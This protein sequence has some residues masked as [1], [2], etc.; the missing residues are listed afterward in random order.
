[1]KTDPVCG[2]N[3][4]EAG[5]IHKSIFR[6][7]SYVFCSE[8]CQEAFEQHPLLYIEQEQTPPSERK[9]VVVG[10]GAVGSTFAYA[11]MRSGLAT[12]I[13]L[14]GRSPEKV[15]AHVMDLNH[16][17]MFVPPVDIY[18][19]TYADCKNA[20][21]V[22]VTSGVAQKPGESRIDLTKRNA[23][24]FRKI[25]PL[26]AREDPNSILVVTNPVDVLTYAAI[27]ISG[28]PMNR[29][30]GSGT[31]LDTARF[32]YLL[33][34][35]CGVDSRNVH[36]YILGEHG[37]SEVPA[38]SKVDIGGVTLKNYCPSCGK[39]CPREEMEGIFSQ[40]RNAAYEIIQGKG[41]TNFAIGL[42]MVRITEAIL[43]NE[44]SIL[45]VST[46]VDGLYNIRDVCLS[47]PA[48][49]NRNGVAKQINLDLEEDEVEMLR[50]SA[51]LLKKSIKEIGL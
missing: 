32:R 25:I 16:G 4:D 28:M 2:M 34:H 51:E 8:H 40:V 26:I 24:V 17:L 36:G 48:V 13:A 29:I 7:K 6:G 9:V 14:V 3:V 11:L 44:N 33:S 23:E 30:I 22:A 49:L 21:M 43:R 12:T 41:V 42:A 37:D 19:G 35:H 46:L 39:N 18:E 50:A 38:W 45:S 47:V 1:M 20:D 5:A 15:R 27:K 31:V 10:T